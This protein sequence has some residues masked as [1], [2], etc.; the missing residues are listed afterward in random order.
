MSHFSSELNQ[1]HK[2]FIAAQAMFFVATAPSEGG[3][4]NLSP[5]GLDSFRVLGPR[6]VAYLD[7]TGSGNET[8]AHLGDNGRITL[9]F[10]SFSRNPLIMR[11]FGK[12]RSVQRDDP[13]WESLYSQFRDTAGVRQIMLID[14]EDVQTTCGYGVPL[15]EL[16]SPRDTLERWAE[17]KSPKELEAYRSK[18]NLT[19]IDGLPTGLKPVLP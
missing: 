4:I 18:N 13:T 2:E 14:I 3:H 19:S 5:K 15:Y 1:T 17:S 12:G 6:Q 9:M 10:C 7:I 8:A 11:L 16:I